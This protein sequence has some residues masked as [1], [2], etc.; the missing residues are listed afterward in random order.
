LSEHPGR[1]ARGGKLATR[2]LRGH[3]YKILYRNFKDRTGDKIDLVCRDGDTLVFVEVKT[4]GD[5]QFGRPHEAVDR[6]K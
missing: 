4:C 5:E 2:F 1:G 6:Q 3:G